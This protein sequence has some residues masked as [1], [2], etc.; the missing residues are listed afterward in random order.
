MLLPFQAFKREKSAMKADLQEAL[1]EEDV[2]E[3]IVWNW[4]TVDCE[5]YHNGVQDLIL[6]KFCSVENL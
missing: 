5:D 1:Q 6:V 4:E 3:I 2:E